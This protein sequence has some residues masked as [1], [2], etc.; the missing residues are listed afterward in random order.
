[1]AAFLVI[2]APFLVQPDQI[3]SLT[4]QVSEESSWSPDSR[5]I[6]FDSNRAGK[7]T[8]LLAN[9]DGGARRQ[10]TNLTEW[11]PSTRTGR[12]TASGSLSIAPWNGA[13]RSCGYLRR[14]RPRLE[15]G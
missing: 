7:S 15:S 3:L 10:I 1:M 6:V 2:L 12:R 5:W 8:K 9:A 4:P 11:R 14:E 13:A